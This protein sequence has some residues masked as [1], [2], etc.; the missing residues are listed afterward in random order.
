MV[1]REYGCHVGTS[2]HGAERIAYMAIAASHDEWRGDLKDTRQAPV[3]DGADAVDALL[4]RWRGGDK[5]I[6][7]Q[8]AT[9]ELV[10]F[11]PAGAWGCPQDVKMGARRAVVGANDAPRF[12]PAT[13]RQLAPDLWFD[14]DRCCLLIQHKT[15]VEERDLS[16]QQRYL[17]AL[18]ARRPG[19]WFSAGRLVDMLMEAGLLSE[20][21]EWPEHCVKQL[22]YEL[23]L[24]LG[25]EYKRLLRT[26]R[27]VGYGLFTA[28]VPRGPHEPSAA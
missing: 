12:I 26:K 1:P 11:V 10:I 19:W 15:G 3:A 18:L 4:A 13:A 9:G 17:L 14:E 8:L 16:G 20:E 5:L 28:S 25:D 7:H 27:G 21:A 24:R 6:V 22:V 2:E 23:R